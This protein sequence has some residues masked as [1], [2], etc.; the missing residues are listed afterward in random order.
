MVEEYSYDPWGNRRMPETWQNDYTNTTNPGGTGILYRGYT[1]HEQ[2]DCFA[3]INMNGRMYDPVLGRMLS[4]D[5]YTHSGTQGLNRYSYVFNNPLKY[6][7]PSGELPWLVP[8]A[9]AITGAYV[10]GASANDWEL[11]FWN[12]EPNAKT[13][14]GII[15]GGLM[16]ASLGVGINIAAGQGALV[17]NLSKAA[18]K[19]IVGGNTSGFINMLSNYDNKAGIGWHSLAYFAS[20]FA[21]GAAGAKF[22]MLGGMSI[23]GFA[24]GLTGIALRNAEEINAYTFWQDM[25]GGAL[26]TYAGLTYAKK[27]AGEKGKYL[28]G[29]TKFGKGAQK[30]LSYG[31]QSTAADFAY[32][33]QDKFLKRDLEDHL[34]IFL[35]GGIGSMVS[36]FSNNDAL[37]LS[38]NRFFNY[39]AYSMLGSSVSFGITGM[40]KSGYFKDPF[41]SKYWGAKTFSSVYKTIMSGL[42]LSRAY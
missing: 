11:A 21:G 22:G 34:G 19:V 6:T 28:F 3:L 30:F 31:L 29:E 20:G 33:D 1:F 2:L 36:G 26:S 13:F 39:S 18:Q 32:T 17:G 8:V 12:W 25:V 40:A 16:G 14:S 38:E 4:A 35:A 24:N 10:G 9:L 37:I 15:A 27:F 5:N 41:Y 42:I 23:G 7:D